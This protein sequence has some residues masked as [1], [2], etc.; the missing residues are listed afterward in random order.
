MEEVLA[1]SAEQARKTGDSHNTH[2]FDGP[3]KHISLN[4]TL[5][6]KKS[7]FKLAAEFFKP[8]KD[9]FPTLEHEKRGKTGLPWN[10]FASLRGPRESKKRPSIFGAARCRGSSPQKSDDIGNASLIP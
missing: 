10:T 9:E 3:P 6:R 4:K 5:I 8:K 7:V 1:T 2:D